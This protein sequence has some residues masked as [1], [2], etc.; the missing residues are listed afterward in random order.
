MSEKTGMFTNG[1]D[2]IDSIPLRPVDTPAGKPLEATGNA[3]SIG[4]LVSNATA[5]VSSLVRSEIE[6]AKTE[7]VG[8]AKKAGVGGGLLA[9]AG[10]IG[11]FSLLFFFAFLAYLIGLWLPMWAAWLI[12]FLVMVAIA[13]ILA[14]IGLASIKKVKKPERTV[15]SMKSLAEVVPGKKN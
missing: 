1:T 3:G 4:Q 13:G 8:S 7:I 14:A 10:V 6:L 2:T 5:Q 11:L 12:I 15:E 9:A